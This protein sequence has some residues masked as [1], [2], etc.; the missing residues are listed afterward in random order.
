MAVAYIAIRY[1]QLVNLIF[2]SPPSVYIPGAIVILLLL[3]ALRRAT[4]WAL[5]VIVLVFLA[6]GLFGNLM[7]GRLAGRAQSWQML[8]GYMTFD[9]NGILG[10]P[11]AV[12]ATVIV[13]FILFGNLLSVTGGSKF[14]TDAA[15]IGMGR[16]RGGSMKISVLASALFGSISGSAVANVVATGVVT[17]PMIKRDGYPAHKAAAIEAV[18]STGGQLMPP[19]MG[20][21]AFLMAELLQIR[22]S[23]SRPS[24]RRC[25][26]TRP[27]SSRPTSRPPASASRASRARRYRP[28]VSSRAGCIS[29]SPSP[30]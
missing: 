18:S 9:T 25:S 14:F 1:P 24:C 16:F 7:P 12:A 4:G 30:C 21:A 19:V 29:C 11:M 27:C 3:E 17:I 22:T 20:A 28:A 15:L 10:L 5:V 23:C 26:I 8:S 6:Y 2:S 13:A